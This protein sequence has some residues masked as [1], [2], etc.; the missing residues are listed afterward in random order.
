MA[1][2]RDIRKRIK[3]VQNIQRITKT[4][5]MIATAKFQSAVRRSSGTKPYTKKIAELVGELASAGAGTIDHP[6]LTANENKKGKELILV[7][8]SNRGFCGGYNGNVL[9]MANRYMEENNSVKY[10][11][12]VVGKKGT[13]FFRFINKPIRDS[14]I[15]FDDKP[16]Y[17]DVEVIA[18]KYIESFINGEYDAVR[19]GY[20][21]FISNSRQE[22]T[23]LKLLPMEAPKVEGAEAQTG[24]GQS[25]YEF[26][27]D[28]EELLSELLPLSIKAQLFQCFND[29]VVSEQI[30]R[31]VAMKAATDNAGKMNKDL[32]RLFNRVRQAQITTELTEI[33][34]G[35]AALE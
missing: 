25:I 13:S 3:A 23:L 22:P 32:K 11:I 5:Q 14:Y 21:N 10:V 26:S 24:T 17:D 29:A 34:S 9:R 16:A 20:M 35:A 19:V 30:A 6:L 28:P 2:A 4:M 7:L 15:E 18:S 12:D 31:M 1:N 33:I 27:P 8:S